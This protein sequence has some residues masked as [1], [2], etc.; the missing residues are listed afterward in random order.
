MFPDVP[1]E[2]LQKLLKE[3]NS[4]LVA[5]TNLLLPEV[6]HNDNSIGYDFDFYEED[7]DNQTESKR[8]KI[9]LPSLSNGGVS[10]IKTKKKQDDKIVTTNITQSTG[11][12]KINRILEI[13]PDIPVF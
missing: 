6:D 5:V 11:I 7:D 9:V 13:L 10:K 2:T 8:K 3:N 4:D 1:Q 12:G